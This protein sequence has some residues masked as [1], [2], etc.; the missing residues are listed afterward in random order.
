MNFFKIVVL[1][2]TLFSFAACVNTRPIQ[3]IQGKFDTAQ[4]S[5]VVINESVVQ[6]ADVISITVFSD[7]PNATAIYNLANSAGGYLVDDRGNIQM[8]GVGELHVEGLNKKQL[9]D[10]LNSKLK[11]FLTNP[12]YS[13]RLINYKV[14]L[15]GEVIREGVYTVP[16]EKIN[17][18]EAIGLAGG[19]TIYA[20]RE[21]V[22]VVREFNGKREFARLDLTSPEIF[23]S[24]YYFLQQNDLVVVEQTRAKLSNSDQTTARNISLATSIISTLAFLYTIF[25]R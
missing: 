15:L 18:F 3:Y 16:N 5:K 10:L 14:S 25:R 4:L 6:H 17:I 24:P 2:A 22:M 21:N 19:L 12:Y 8:Q 1:F 9:T 13:I 11:V 23:K 7:N 20:R